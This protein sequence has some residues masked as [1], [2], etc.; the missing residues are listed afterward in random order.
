MERVY[1]VVYKYEVFSYLSTVGYAKSTTVD[2]IE[3]I[4]RT[5]NRGTGG[6]S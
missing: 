3:G 5:L 2:Q 4:L 6:K 1:A